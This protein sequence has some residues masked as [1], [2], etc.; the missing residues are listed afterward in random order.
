[1]HVG[2][3]TTLCTDIKVHDEIGKKVEDDK[4]QLKIK[5]SDTELSCLSKYKCKTILKKA[6]EEEAFNYLLKLKEHHSK[7]EGIGIQ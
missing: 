6:V 1:M 5:L 2:P 7:I 4:K 3:K